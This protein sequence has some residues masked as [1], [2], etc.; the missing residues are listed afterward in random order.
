MYFGSATP[1]L[2]SLL[3]RAGCVPRAHGGLGNRQVLE[4]GRHLHASGP[5]Q[6][7]DRRWIRRESVVARRQDQKPQLVR[8]HEEGHRPEGFGHRLLQ[9]PNED[10]RMRRTVGFPVIQPSF[11]Q[12]VAG[13]EAFFVGEG[14]A[15]GLPREGLQAGH[16]VPC[17]SA[18]VNL[19]RE[20]EGLPLQP[21]LAEGE[22]T[23]ARQGPGCDERSERG[24]LRRVVEPLDGSSCLSRRGE[25]AARI[26]LTIPVRTP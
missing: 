21:G 22:D 17:P 4:Q 18:S 12:G 16:P 5:E 8:V 25:R 3:V 1:R 9:G 11:H 26:P 24:W 23:G 15:E 7:D 6:G 14:L 20:V 2:M 13:L 10:V 19:A